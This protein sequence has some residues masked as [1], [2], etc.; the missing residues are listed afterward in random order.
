MMRRFSTCAVRS[1]KQKTSGSNKKTWTPSKNSGEWRNFRK[2]AAYSNFQ[3]TA[4][5]VPF[6]DESLSILKSS[7]LE[8]KGMVTYPDDIQASLINL[9]TFLPQQNNE[10]F[11]THSSLLRA[12]TEQILT[13]MNN[14]DSV[15]VLGGAGSGKSTVLS[16][17]Q[18]LAKLEKWVVLHLPRAMALIDGSTDHVK[19]EDGDFYWQ[20]MLVKRWFKK[21]LKANKDVLSPEATK[22]LKAGKADSVDALFEQLEADGNKVLLTLDG[23]NAWTHHPLALNTSADNK[24]IYHAKL[25]LPKLFLEYFSGEK[26]LD[27]AVIAA[28][29]GNYKMNKTV[30][31]ALG[32]AETHAYAE[33]DEFDPE[34]AERL[35]NAKPL[36]V[37]S[38]SLQE[39]SLYLQYLERA[40]LC[41]EAGE[42]FVKDTYL[43]SG[44]GN[45]RALLKT[46]INYS[47]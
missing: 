19:S 43:L 1:F 15:L 18:A 26:K 14:G 9:G 4:P 41:P 46:F 13:H 47:F 23:L 35:K 42:Q 17:A 33:L 39:T 36:D 10:L 37:G 45:P 40:G 34:L 28:T 8:K 32:R 44:N 38:F 5:E 12:E 27:G 30:P 24:R 21:I 3:K 7:N 2:A 31:V 25:Q 11:K 29:T 20:P 22:I 16:Q 6:N